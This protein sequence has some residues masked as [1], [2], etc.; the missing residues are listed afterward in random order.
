MAIHFF[1][2]IG[3]A[4]IHST[5]IQPGIH[6]FGHSEADTQDGKQSGDHFSPAPKPSKAIC[7]INPMN[8]P[9]Q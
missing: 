7:E 6:G 1:G 2:L 4:G 9:R 3:S 5:G 8:E